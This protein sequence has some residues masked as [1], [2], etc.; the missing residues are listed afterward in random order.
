MISCLHTLQSIKVIA[1]QK[2]LKPL[3]N[4]LRKSLWPRELSTIANWDWLK[5]SFTIFLDTISPYWW[6]QVSKQVRVPLNSLED[7]D[8]KPSM[9]LMMQPLFFSL[10]V[11]SGEELLPLVL[12]QM[13]QTDIDISVLSKDWISN[14]LTMDAWTHYNMLWKPIQILLH[15]WLNLSKD[16]EV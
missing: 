12:V 15:S 4:R 13:T 16:K 2:S 9:F 10:K 8:M 6:I 3:S 7:G 5:K 14:S 11:I 1:I